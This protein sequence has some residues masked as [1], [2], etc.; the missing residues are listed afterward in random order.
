MPT[1]ASLLSQTQIPVSIIFARSTPTQGRPAAWQALG[2]VAGQQFAG[3]RRERTLIRSGPEGE[4]YLWRGFALRLRRELAPD[5]LLNLSG[6]RPAVFVICRRTPE[7]EPVPAEATLSMD[8]AQDLEAT[9]LR[10][11]TDEVLQVPMPPEVYRWLE[12]FV[13]QHYQPPPP[14]TGR[15]RDAKRTKF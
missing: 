8:E 9:D 14:K 4:Q 13:A 1:D 5:Y 6:E 3:D 2:V 7:G 12:A 11:G 15:R 10:S